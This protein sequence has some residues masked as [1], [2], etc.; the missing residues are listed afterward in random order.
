MSDGTGIRTAYLKP[1]RKVRLDFIVHLRNIPKKNPEN[2]HL[3]SKATSN[4]LWE[5][6]RKLTGND[7]E[8]IK[9][10]RNLPKTVVL[11]SAE[12]RWS[13]IKS[14]V[15]IVFLHKLEQSWLT[16]VSLFWQYCKRSSQLHQGNVCESSFEHCHITT[17]SSSSKGIEKHQ[18]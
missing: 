7:E 6:N 3:T 18:R 10:R 8:T 17:P 13:I 5:K 2:T 14:H 15:F 1:P 12:E 16:S 9:W 4:N 11:R